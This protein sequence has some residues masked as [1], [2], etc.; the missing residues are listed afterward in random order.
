MFAAGG[1]II[2]GNEAP[3]SQN[4]R[5]LR[6]PRPGRD[7]DPWSLSALCRY[8]VRG[9]AAGCGH[10]RQNSGIVKAQANH[11]ADHWSAGEP[12]NFIKHRF[13]TRI[14]GSDIIP[15]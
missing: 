5:H 14:R 4:R 13:R 9:P 2:M 6:M 7:F 1:A 8:S 3:W 12:G 10:W 11:A 15:D